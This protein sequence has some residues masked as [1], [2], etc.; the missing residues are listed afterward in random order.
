MK[1]WR[2]YRLRKDWQFKDIIIEEGQKV[3]N[4]SFTIFFA[5]NNH[6][7]C[8]F[9]I[10]T[11]KKL[12]N[13]AT[14]RN[15]YKRQVKGMLISHLKSEEK[16]QLNSCQTSTEHS[17]FDLVIIIRH[18]YLKNDFV[19]NQKNLYKLLDLVDRM[20]GQSDGRNYN[21][22]PQKSLNAI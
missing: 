7:N 21:F 11:P 5:P 3:V 9:G 15:F 6:C 1:L 10:S 4:L 18:P 2:P 8:R 12:I 17:H 19:T 22:W 16:K 14:D 13:L 20:K